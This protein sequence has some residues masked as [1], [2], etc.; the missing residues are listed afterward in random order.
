MAA[1]YL[2]TGFPGDMLNF[3]KELKTNN[4]KEWF[5]ENKDR[6]KKSVIEPGQSFVTA[7][8]RK[9]KELDNSIIYDTRTNGSG[10][11]FRIY[12]D[13]RFSKDKTP[14]KTFLGILFWKGD[15]KKTECP[16]FYFHLETDRLY[17]YTGLHTFMKDDL[18]LYRKGVMADGESLL[19]ILADF[20]KKGYQTGGKHYKRIPRGFSAEGEKAEYLLY[21]GLHSWFEASVPPE[22]QT[23]GL[24]DYCFEHF[25]TMQPLLNW[26]DRNVTST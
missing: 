6:Y 4:N 1:D 26:I 23:E 22:L 5:S 8:G 2:F 14:Y 21:K 19:E 20:K 17:L 11:I 24:I 15:K 3:Y 7:M 16:G 18:D 12:K 25:K 10:S 13:V 9:L